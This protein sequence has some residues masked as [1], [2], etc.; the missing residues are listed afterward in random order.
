MIG[1]TASFLIGFGVGILFVVFL[2]VVNAI[3]KKNKKENK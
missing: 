3:A 1:D 2:V